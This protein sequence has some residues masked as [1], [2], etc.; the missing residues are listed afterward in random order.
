MAQIV[1]LADHGAK[2]E[3]CTREASGGHSDHYFR[4]LTIWS[5]FVIYYGFAETPVALRLFE[6]LVK[7]SVRDSSVL[8]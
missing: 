3:C 7:G 6:Q 4:R 2:G 8:V 1:L 5:R